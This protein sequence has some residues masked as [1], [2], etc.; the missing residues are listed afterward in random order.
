MRR[1]FTIGLVVLVLVASPFYA[2]GQMFRGGLEGG[3]TATQASQDQA[4]GY[5][6][7]GWYASVFTNMDISEHARLQLELMYIQ[8]GSRD[9]FDPY[10]E[11]HQN[12]NKLLFSEKQENNDEPPE[13][14]YRNYKLYL[15][16]VEIPLVLQFDFSAATRLPYIEQ[17]AGEFGLSVSTVVGHFE[18]DEGLNI[19]DDMADLQPFHFAE[20]NLLTGLLYPITDQLNFHVRY[21]QGITPFRPPASEEERPREWYELFGQWYDWGQFNTVLSFGLSYTFYAENR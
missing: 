13:E 21:S 11:E 15:H 7:L 4:S 6:K 8:K 12:G 5:D 17:L 20:L 9:F 2:S 14:S 1:V 16:Y 10:H 3:L 18:E 19:T